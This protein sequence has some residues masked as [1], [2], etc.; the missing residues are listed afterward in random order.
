MAIADRF[1]LSRSDAPGLTILWASWVSTALFTVT[2]AVA[3]ATESANV[4]VTVVDLVLFAIGCVVFVTAFV[5]GAQRSRT[6]ELGIGGWFF[7]AGAAP[8]PV[9]WHLLGSFAVQC[10]VS[11]VAAWVGFARTAADDLNPLAFSVL[12][13]TLGL[14]FCGL[15]GARHGSFGPRI[16]DAPVVGVHTG[17]SGRDDASVDKNGDHG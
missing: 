11:I 1:A 2:S 12:V 9:Q 14:A 3:V 4:A 13:P 15:W 7:L 5:T 16:F 10:L 8:R 6:H 17:K